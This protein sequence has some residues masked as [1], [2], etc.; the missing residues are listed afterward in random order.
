M[1]PEFT[2]SEGYN[3]TFEIVDRV[4]QLELWNPS[5][6]GKILVV[7]VFKQNQFDMKANI[8]L[9]NWENGIGFLKHEVKIFLTKVFKNKAFL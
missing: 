1:L 2:D 7:H 9:E 5:P 6:N 8:R 4:P 3:Y